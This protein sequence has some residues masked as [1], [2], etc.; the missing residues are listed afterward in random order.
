MVEDARRSCALV[1]QGREKE[2]AV[3]QALL[4]GARAGRSGVLVVHGDAG[5]GKTSL[6]ERALAQASDGMRIARA[7]G[8][9][10]EMEL[11]YA[12]LHQL[13]SGMVGLADQLPAPQ[14][15][16]LETALGLRPASAPSPFL[17]GLSVLGLLAEAAADKPLVCLIDDVQWLDEASRRAVAFGA[18]RLGLEGIA[19]VFVMRAVGGDLD[20]LPHLSVGG[21]SDADA[22]EV[23]GQVLPGPVDP[24]VGDQLL[25]EARGNPLALREI[26]RALGPTELAGAFTG[27]GTMPL[28]TRIEQSLLTQFA[29]LSRS[30]RRLMLL[31]ATEPTGDPQ[32]LWQAARRLSLGSEEL[33]M[34]E[35]AEVLT[36]GTR[37]EFRH[38]LVR[39]A[40]YGAA[41]AEERRRVH[42]VLA[43]VTNAED[44]PDRRAWHR[45][46]ATLEPDE[47]VAAELDR[48]AERARQ[49]GG[50][51]TAAAF[52]ERAA[53][54]S[55]IPRDRAKRM[56]AAARARHEAGAPEAATAL[57]N[58]VRVNQ[59]DP[60]DEAALFQLGAQVEFALTRD[61]SAAYRLL[62]AARHLSRLDPESARSAY[63]EALFVAIFI[64]GLT[65]DDHDGPAH[66]RR[67]RW[68]DLGQ[69]VLDATDEDSPHPVDL[70]LR[71]QALVA[72]GERISAVPV[73]RQAIAALLEAAPD[74]IAPQWMGLECVAAI[75]VWDVHAL[76]TL[77]G[78]QVALARTHGLLSVL[79]TALSFA[80]AACLVEGRLDDAQQLADELD[81]IKDATGHPFPRHHRL[82]T[83]AWR[84][85][86]REVDRLAK[87]LRR[88]ASTRGDG[89]VLSVANFAEAIL[90]NG[91][92]L[93]ADAVAAG[94]A[95]LKH[96]REVTYTSRVL[97]ELVE[98]AVR[99]GDRAL[100][101]TA[102]TELTTLAG[103][104][105]THW[106]QG[107]LAAARAQTEEG[108]ETETHHQD[109]I[110]YFRRGGMAVYEGRARL[111]YGEWLR[112]HRRRID[113][114]TQ[115]RAAQ[116]LLSDRGAH[117]FAAR[118]ARE[119]EA[120]GETA[121][122]RTVVTGEALTPQEANVARLARDGLTNRDISTRLFI[123]VR[124]V[125][126]HLR[127]VFQKIGISSR[128]EL[129]NAMDE[130]RFPSSTTAGDLLG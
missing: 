92:G 22:R 71:G 46:Q 62:D 79:P 69:A 99:T 27:S 8:V 105:E 47:T 51:A 111:A 129:T 25:A 101:T 2:S 49:R 24:R 55:P 45:G 17:V 108:P 14:R 81:V 118:A 3:L 52:H 122:S 89:S 21:L 84:G 44:D 126:Y 30:A 60:R 130:E 112:R 56:L 50:A 86:A 102:L 64:G 53:A 109:A 12:G 38:P 31:A 33:E 59:L 110:A 74:V 65:E 76:R 10:S 73:L 124:T 103:L 36:V 116:E 127:K 61:H 43:E 72:V 19:V 57:I 77:A 1:F 7:V 9:E 48:S 87:E 90:A 119:L 98:A 67:P 78:R 70:L 15:D 75:D 11:P 114:R 41:G 13:C 58:H 96:I 100:A 123:S 16:A 6:V 34:A 88:G 42:A 5:V 121:R 107:A 66:S 54:L 104:I 80:G 120:T 85:D 106:A 32:L 26:P 91:L 23:L 94:T 113:A 63:H 4:D 35:R 97:C 29:S 37:V 39:S 95:E 93:H 117:A 40:V 28:T 125:E 128:R 83:A 18:R 68:A 20:G 115:L 82:L